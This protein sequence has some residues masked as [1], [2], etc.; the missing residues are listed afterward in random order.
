MCNLFGCF[1]CPSLICRD[2]YKQN[3]KFIG[4][5]IPTR[6]KH[7]HWLDQ[8]CELEEGLSNWLT[9]GRQ[10]P[11]QVFM[12]QTHLVMLQSLLSQMKPHSGDVFNLCMTGIVLLFFYVKT[13]LTFYMQFKY[14]NL[15]FRPKYF[16]CVCVC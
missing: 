11:V 15:T 13:G 3:K 2:F 5:S 4:L 6:P 7:Q 16:E 9:N 8:W 14:T 12:F 1:F 10:G